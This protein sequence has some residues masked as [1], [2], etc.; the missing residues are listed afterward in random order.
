M[1]GPKREVDLAHSADERGT[2]SIWAQRGEDGSLTI[3]GQDL[4]AA[5]ER[6]FGSR[7]YE[8]AWTIAPADVP[9]VAEV[10]GGQ[11]GD[12]PLDALVRWSRENGDRDPGTL[13]KDG[14]IIAAFWSRVGD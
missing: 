2:R 1:S 6:A 8:W 13:L 10:F 12:D 5:V 7:E 14:G 3:E 11:A 4:G 9:R